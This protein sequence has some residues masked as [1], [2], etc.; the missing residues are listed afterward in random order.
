MEEE[1]SR[2]ARELHDVITHSV[3]VMMVQAGAA[4]KVMTMAPERAQQALLAVES[5]GRAAMTELRHVMGLLTIDGDDGRRPA[6]VDL[7]PPPGLGDVAALAA[8]VRDTGVPVEVRVTGSPAPLPAG[9]DLAAY[10][11]VQEAL[12]NTVK[13][14]AGAHVEVAVDHGPGVL[15]IEVADT[16]GVPTAAARSGSGRG[17]I[18][19]RERLAVYG[20]TLDAGRLA[21]GGYR[22]R[23]TIPADES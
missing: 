9:V 23:A 13:H 2:I 18:G 21:T 3:S 10:R 12:T 11:V 1:R 14:A 8:R 7:A 16:G 6:A 17:L 4:R 5:G 19:L 22:V 20:G 15:R